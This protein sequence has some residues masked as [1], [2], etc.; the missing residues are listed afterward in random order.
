MDKIPSTQKS[1]FFTL[2]VYVV[3]GEFIN[4]ISDLIQSGQMVIS[5][6]HFVGTVTRNIDDDVS[7][8]LSWVTVVKS[9]SQSQVIVA[10]L[11]LQNA[12]LQFL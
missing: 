12:G 11:T 6:R 4:L 2:L 1:I 5:P 3:V 7:F 10:C 9:T 8:L